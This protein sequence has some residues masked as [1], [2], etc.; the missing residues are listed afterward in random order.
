MKIMLENQY[1]RTA[2]AGCEGGAAV[3]PDR[4]RTVRQTR[5][6]GERS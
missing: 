5:R 1:L 6:H 2:Y 4:I 3:S